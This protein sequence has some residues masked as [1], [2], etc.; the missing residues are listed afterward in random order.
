MR[1]SGPRSYDSTIRPK[2]PRFVDLTG[3]LFG[4]LTVINYAG[5]DGRRHYWRCECICGGFVE[6]L[7]SNLSQ[8]ITKS[9]G[10]LHSEIS[11]GVEIHGEAQKTPEYAAWS[12]MKNRCLSP[13]CHAYADYGG[14]GITVCQRWVDDYEAFLADMGRKPDPSLSLDRI[15][16][17][18][19][20]EPGNCR[21]ATRKQQANNRRPPRA[22]QSNHGEAA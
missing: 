22:H 1:N 7:R 14:R 15:D 10:C 8:G 2:D 11:G 20:Y 17:D 13:S 5:R 4:R 6:V 18:G 16:N 12:S 19:N 9:C 3:Q 21:W